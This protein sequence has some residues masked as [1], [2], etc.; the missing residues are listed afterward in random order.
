MRRVAEAVASVLLAGLVTV[1]VVVWGG[2][3]AAA[4]N[5]IR[6]HQ[7]FFGIVNGIRQHSGTTPIIKTVCPGPGGTT[8]HIQGGQH[9]AV[10]HARS[11]SGYTGYF[12]QIYAWISRDTSQGGPQQVKFTRY[13]TPASMP[14]NAQVPCDGPG[15]VTFSSC[16]AFAPCAAGWTPT[17]MAVRFE[18]VAV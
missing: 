9:L 1:P 18:N 4:D 12:R 3:L 15:K 6:P 14:T 2:G 11:G 7:H 8:G 17:T 16:P 13:N 5:Q 10:G